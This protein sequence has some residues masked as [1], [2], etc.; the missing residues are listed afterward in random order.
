MQAGVV[1]EPVP[2]E[3]DVAVLGGG[4]GGLAVAG[5]LALEGARVVVLEA[6]DSIAH[7]WSGRHHGVAGLGLADHPIRLVRALGDTVAREL[8]EWTAESL[9]MARERNLIWRHGALTAALG[10]VERDEIGPSVA[11]LEKWGRTVEPLDASAVSARLGSDRFGPG[12][13]DPLAGVIDPPHA[14]GVVAQA[15]QAAG[16]TV[17]LGARTRL[18]RDGHLETEVVGEQ[19][20]VGFVLRADVVVH[21]A[22]PAAAVLDPF[23]GDKVYPVRFQMQHLQSRHGGDLVLPALSAQ[24]SYIQGAPRPDGTYVLGGCRWA[25]PHLE[26]GEADPTA[27][28]EAVDA[29]LSQVR[30]GA[31]SDYLGEVD[32]I[33]RSAGIMT[34]T[35]DGL[36]IVGPLPGRVQHISCL[37]FNGRPWSHALRAAQAVR[38][39]LMDGRSHGMPAVLSPQRFV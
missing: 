6:S 36:P 31:L 10:D 5:L 7:G 14:L 1:G 9:A 22:G 11:L 38:D 32:V 12:W 35:C 20:G 39:G 24:L 2:A 3:A 15:A 25:T 30:E 28:S 8:M 16:A 19:D 34:F 4:L 37:G 26:V 33:E 23:F 27:L 18:T 29:R 17:C 13:W 21:C